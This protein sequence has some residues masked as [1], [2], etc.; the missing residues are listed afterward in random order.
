MKP[1]TSCV[2]YTKAIIITISEQIHF[3]CVLMV[4]Q[5]DWFALDYLLTWCLFSIVYP[6]S[7][8]LK[9][10]S[11]I[12]VCRMFPQKHPS[13]VSQLLHPVQ[14][15]GTDR[16]QGLFEKDICK[17]SSRCVMISSKVSFTVMR[18]FLFED[19]SSWEHGC[20]TAGLVCF[21]CIVCFFLAAVECHL[22]AGIVQTLV[23]V[24]F[25]ID[26]KLGKCFTR[27]LTLRTFDLHY[28]SATYSVLFHGR[29]PT[30]SL[31]E[32]RF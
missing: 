18:S 25:R 1:L 14:I 11:L 9:L 4:C 13:S 20:F 3:K 10:L 12:F 27:R 5:H 8:N 21:S 15:L 2:C 16:H 30:H 26:K 31:S 17:S 32:N 29:W 6:L 7:S 24:R 23:W 22:N 19:S 28:F